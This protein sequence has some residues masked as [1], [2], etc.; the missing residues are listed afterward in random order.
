MGRRAESADS[1]PPR[2]ASKSLVIGWADSPT[3]YS[4][5]QSHPSATGGGSHPSEH[6][7]SLAN[8]ARVCRK[9]FR[10]VKRGSKIRTRQFAEG[11]LVVD[12]IEDAKF[13]GFHDA[14]QLS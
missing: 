9:S 1:S 11:C 3:P 14:Q 7:I 5:V 6:R 8:R 2:H 13:P 4:N 12:E 10:S